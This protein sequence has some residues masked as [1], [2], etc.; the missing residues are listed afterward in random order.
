M[1]NHIVTMHWDNIDPKIISCQKEVFRFFDCEIKQISAHGIGTF[2]EGEV[3]H[4]FE[5][6]A[7]PY[8]FVMDE[9]AHSIC[10]GAAVD[11][12]ARMKRARFVSY[13]EGVF[14]ATKRL[15]I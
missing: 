14:K 4:L 6:H 15:E 2:Y 12:F 5:S 1:A 13:F 3:F 7:S 8:Q 11:Y 10:S 9:V